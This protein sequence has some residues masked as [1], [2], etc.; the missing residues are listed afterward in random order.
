MIFLRRPNGKASDLPSH[1]WYR[2]QYPFYIQNITGEIRILLDPPGSFYKK[3][4]CEK[5][6]KY[7]G[8]VKDLRRCPHIRAVVMN[9]LPVPVAE[10][11][12]RSGM[13]SVVFDSATPSSAKP[14]GLYPVP[15]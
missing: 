6:L 3:G 10:V 13:F 9:N 7:F 5:G 12:M 2:H 1:E 4:R 11:F 8:V 15:I 14:S